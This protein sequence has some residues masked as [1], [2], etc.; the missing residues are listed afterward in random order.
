M[1]DL[2]SDTVTKPTAQMRKLREAAEVGD[3]VYGEDL[4]ISNILRIN[5]GNFGKSF[6]IFDVKCQKMR[7]IMRQHCGDKSRIVNIFSRDIVFENE[8]F[9]FG[10]NVRY[11]II[12]GKKTLKFSDLIFGFIN[13]QT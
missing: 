11:V 1:I 7:D 12:N 13:R 5:Y 2:R 10:K 8:I 4:K 9:P 3:D 6:E